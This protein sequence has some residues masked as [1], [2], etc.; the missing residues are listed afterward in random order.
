MTPAQK[1]ASD[2]IKL[3]K[4]NDWM[5][6]KLTT[7]NYRGFPDALIITGI[8][9]YFCEIK[10]KK[11]TIKPVQ[12]TVHERLNQEVERCF[13]ARSVEDVERF[14]VERG[15]E[16]KQTNKKTICLF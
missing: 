3:C 7:T 6:V 8:N 5:W 14:M 15:Y 11:D 9:T 2:I 16:L 10:A 13:V 4:A 1:V 12:Y